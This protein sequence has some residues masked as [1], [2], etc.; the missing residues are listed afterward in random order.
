M[1]LVAFSC[2]VTCVAAGLRPG[3]SWAWFAVSLVFVLVWATEAV[4]V[5]WGQVMGPQVLPV[6]LRLGDEWVWSVLG[7]SVRTR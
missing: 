1:V 6:E 7:M 2:C 5:R 3:G 4:A